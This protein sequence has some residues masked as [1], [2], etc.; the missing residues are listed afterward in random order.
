[1]KAIKIDVHNTLTDEH[2]ATY[3]MPFDPRKSVMGFYSR[4]WKTIRILHANSEKVDKR[5]IRGSIQLFKLK[6]EK[7]MNVRF[8]SGASLDTPF[9][10]NQTDCDIIKLHIQALQL[11]RS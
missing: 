5:S 9:E 10:L 4:F 8:A 6:S 1:M 11:S 7:R 2:I 3:E